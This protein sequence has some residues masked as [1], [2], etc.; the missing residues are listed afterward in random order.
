MR[1]AAGDGLA[2][3]ANFINTYL[4][5]NG[6]EPINLDKFRTVPS[7]ATGARRIG[8]LTNLMELTIDTSW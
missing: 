7:K 3:H 1:L 5:S 6:A 4:Q 2:V 8:R